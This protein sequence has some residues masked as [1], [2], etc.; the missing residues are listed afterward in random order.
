MGGREGGKAILPPINFGKTQPTR[1]EKEKEESLPSF[2]QTEKEGGFFHVTWG[3][4]GGLLRSGE[5][6]SFRLEKKSSEEGKKEKL[7]FGLRKRRYRHR[8]KNG[9]SE[10][11]TLLLHKLGEGERSLQLLSFRKRCLS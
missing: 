2:P 7:S 1:C 6:K 4:A 5:G 11:K 9:V 3:Q 10:P 8:R